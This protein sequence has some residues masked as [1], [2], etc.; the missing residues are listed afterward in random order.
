MEAIKQTVKV[1]NHQ[2]N[3]TL[4]DDFNAD[5]V[6]VIIL[7]AERKEY[8]IPQ[9]QIDQVRERTENYLK[10]PKDASNIDDFLKEIEDEL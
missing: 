1:I 2:I 5:E 10:N 3:I 9:W 7:P 4:P 6:E 8:T